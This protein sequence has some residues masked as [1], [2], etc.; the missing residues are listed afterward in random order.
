MTLILR[1]VGGGGR[2]GD[3][4]DFVRF[5]SAHGKVVTSAVSYK[6][7]RALPPRTIRAK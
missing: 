3:P 4:Y 5:T 2:G 6:D 7:A 1:R